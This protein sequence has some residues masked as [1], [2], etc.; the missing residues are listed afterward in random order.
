LSNLSGITSVTNSAA[1]SGTAV[2]LNNV[3]EDTSLDIGAN[4]GNTLTLNQAGAGAGSP[5][6]TIDVSLEADA[7]ITTGSAFQV[8]DVETVNITSNSDESGVTHTVTDATLDNTTLIDVGDGSANLTFADLQAASLVLFDG[9]DASN[10]ISLTST[11]DFSGVTGGTA[12]QGGADAD[13][14]DMSG[15]AVSAGTQYQG[16]GGGDNITLDAPGDTISETVVYGSSDDSALSD[17]DTITNFDTAGAATDDDI[18]VSGLSLSTNTSSVFDK[19]D[20]DGD[21]AFNTDADVTDFFD[22]SG[23]DRAI[24]IE[25]DGT[26]SRVYVDTNGN[27][28]FDV[29]SD[30]TVEVAGVT[31]L[32]INDFIVS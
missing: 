7:D 25:N 32:D 24:A 22:E 27:G 26:D 15:A 2:T 19:G 18:D 6:D 12:F 16:N 21:T 3:A 28:D 20:I 11:D 13:T 10:S 1:T 9:S 8:P 30:L 29:D 4:L 23:T 17:L 31:N 5:N 14:I